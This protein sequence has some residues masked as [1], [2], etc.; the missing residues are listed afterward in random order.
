MHSHAR[1]FSSTM[2]AMITAFVVSA[3]PFSTWADGPDPTAAMQAADAAMYPASF[4][5]TVAIS[6]ERPGEA[7]TTM[8]MQVSHKSGRGSFIEFLAPARL[9]G[10]RLLQTDGAL[11]M[12][13]PRAGSRTPLRLSPR[14]SFQG[15]AFSNNDIGDPSWSN[16]YQA[17]L[18]G[19]GVV[20]HPDFGQA[21]VWIIS[22]KALRRDV[23]YGEIRVYL[24]KGDLLP[25][26][27]DYFAKSGLPL[28]VMDLSDFASTAGRLRPRRMVMT[29]AAGTGEK[30]VVLM[31]DLRERTDL[32]DAMFNQSWL[33]R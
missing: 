16:D 8:E 20:D 31:S 15:S 22:G 32:P 26:R 5:L 3:A 21:E 24:K 7:S 9:K 17:S 30:S 18:A 10:T 4:S 29:S 27:I 13:S 11:W 1:R 28:K 6:T 25:L 19:S 23:P 2:I 12:Y 14:E 33:T